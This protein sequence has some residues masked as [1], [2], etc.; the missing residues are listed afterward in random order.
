MK[1]YNYNAKIKKGKAF[2]HASEI[3]FKKRNVLLYWASFDKKKTNCSMND[4]V[5]LYQD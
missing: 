5:Y 1:I 2:M 3:I 4:E